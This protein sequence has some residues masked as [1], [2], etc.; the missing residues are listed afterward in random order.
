MKN[1]QNHNYKSHS[2]STNPN[3][4]SQE[5]QSILSKDVLSLDEILHASNGKSSTPL[6]LDAFSLSH[7]EKQE[8]IKNHIFGIMS[9]LGLDMNDES[10]SDTPLRVAKMYLNE[11]FRGLNPANEPE[12]TLFNNNY[13]YNQMLVERDITIYSTCEHHLVPIIGRAH[14]AY[15]STGKVIGLSKLNRIA[16]YYA[17]RPQVQERLTMQI[18]DALKKALDTDD[19][20]VIIDASHMCVASRGIRDVNSSTTT[21][22]YSGKFLNY[23]TRNEFLSYLKK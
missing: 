11:T 18:S 4:S 21:C 20:A 5:N 3:L 14:I 2:F 1:N 6:R 16:D 23:N 17:R 13:Q 19:V 12:V 15:Y 22:E 8:I 7:E 9:T 10:L